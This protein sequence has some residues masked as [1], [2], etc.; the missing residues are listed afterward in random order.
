MAVVLSHPMTCRRSYNVHG[1]LWYSKEGMYGS[2]AIW[3][4]LE[5]SCSRGNVGSAHTPLTET[6]ISPG[7]LTMPDGPN[8]LPI[9]IIPTDRNKYVPTTCLLEIQPGIWQYNNDN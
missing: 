9:H 3:C 7:L 8:Y 5:G 6:D 4:V 1:Q 2:A